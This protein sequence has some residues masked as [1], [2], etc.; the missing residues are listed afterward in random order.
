MRAMYLALLL[1]FACSQTAASSADSRAV[2]SGA[3]ILSDAYVGQP[4]VVRI[5]NF[6]PERW[7]VGVT[8][9]SNTSNEG[10]P[11][12]HIATLFSDDLGATWSAPVV[13]DGRALTNAYSAPFAQAESGRIAIIYGVNSANVTA[14]P[15]GAPLPRADMLG[16]FALKFSD[17]GGASWPGP[18]CAVPI[19]ATAI[20][21]AN[22]PWNG[23]VR[24]QW[25]VDTVKSFG[26]NGVIFAFTKIGTYVLSPPEEVFL[27]ASPNARVAASC[28]ELEWATLPAGDHGLAPPGGNPGVGEEGH[29]VVLASGG[30]FAVARTAQGFLSAAR[31][32]DASG[33]GGWSATA[34]ARYWGATRPLGPLKH[35]RG[36]TALVR[37]AGGR[38]LLLFYFQS[39]VFGRNPYFL[40]SGREE[41]GEVRFSQPELALY[42]PGYGVAYP[43][44]IE[45]RGGG[46]YITECNK[47]AARS[48]A[49]DGAL[50]AALLAQDTAASIATRALALRFDAAS[51]GATFP[52][53]RLPDFRAPYVRGAG[54]AVCLWVSNHAA[55]RAGDVLLDTR[56]AGS[57]RGRGLALFVRAAGVVALELTD[58]AGHTAFLNTDAACAAPLLSAGAH[59]VAAIADAG[60]R[61]LSLA[62]DGALCDGGNETA[63]GWVFLPP[64]FGSLAGGDASFTLAPTYAGRLL[65][66]GFYEGF[67]YTSEVV[68]NFRAGPPAMP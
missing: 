40:A 6:V 45:A 38:Y 34:F 57:P 55:A 10:A 46:V 15:D 7:V 29:V 32:S 56:A 22:A 37:L 53:P 21:A 48:H 39:A 31:T 64:G 51:A 50:L 58:D 54:A 36:P 30:L 65:G 5:A 1:L 12:T 49:V 23:S 62:V 28:A 33:A 35:G 63:A 16:T 24:M 68:G 14:L 26:A 18:P 25:N 47:T 52:T 59:L 9:N 8:R 42:S 3:L 43:D 2:E 61:V 19:R 60:A 27:L 41:G 66:G 11:G 4:Y 20:D 17:D 67:L 44:I 13:V